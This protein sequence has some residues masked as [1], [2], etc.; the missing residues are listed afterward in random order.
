MIRR[1]YGGAFSDEEI[2]DV[3]A[4]AWVGALRAL[5]RR[6]EELD[7]EQV[8]RYILAAVANQASKELRRRK[9]KPTA[10]LEVADRVADPSGSP[11]E[12]AAGIEQQ[13]VTRDLLA[14][15]PPRRRAV[16]LLR[17]GWGL[18]PEQVRS[19]VSGL[20]ARAYRREITRGVDELTEKLRLLEAGKWCGERE[21][22]LKAFA[23]GLADADEQRQAQAH[24]S[25]CRDC[26][27][28]V[29]RL[30]GRLHDLG[31]AATLP[32][33]IDG[34]DG[35]LSV[36][37]RFGGLAERA[38]E[39]VSGL[40]SRGDSDAI[41]DL[42]ARTA[43]SGGARGAGAAGAGF[44]AKLAGLGAAGK[45]AVAC[46][47]GGVAATACVAAIA[48]G[49]DLPGLGDG[50]WPP[51]QLPAANAPSPDQAAASVPPAPELLPPQVGNEA[52]PSAAEPASTDENGPHEANPE[53]TEPSPPPDPIAPSAPPAEQEFGVAA[54]G[55]PAPDPEPTGS[56]SGP[57]TSGGAT[58]SPAQQEFG[59]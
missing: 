26:A 51:D 17:Y 2:E 10:P 34:I 11:D 55:A 6:H 57:S 46:V 12:R 43:A 47:G 53:P 59:P 20:S 31:G 49:V 16:M 14:S 40:V 56:A 52:P 29:A 15:L 38:R 25:H 45:A 58:A 36:A 8:R 18:E 50:N 23:A 33:G 37:D 48:P 35:S 54:A 19:L 7:D 21:P 22:L 30:S 32:V 28:F 39:A 9:R 13:R 42:A 27:D 4:N 1:A 3:Y 5:A 24:L 44:V 41:A